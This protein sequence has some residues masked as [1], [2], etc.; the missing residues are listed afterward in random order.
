MAEARC[1]RGGGFWSCRSGLALGPLFAQ[2]PHSLAQGPT[3]VG[4]PQAQSHNWENEAPGGFKE[5]PD[6]LP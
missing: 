4:G 5:A 3:W 1:P 6:P 2:P